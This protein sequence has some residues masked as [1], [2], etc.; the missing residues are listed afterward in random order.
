MRQGPNRE[1]VQRAL[2]RVVRQ[3]VGSAR[4]RRWLGITENAYEL[5]RNSAA[6]LLPVLLTPSPRNLTVAIT[7]QCNLR[8]VGCRYGRDY[9]TG[10]QLPTM[11]VKQLLRDAAAAGISTVRLYGGEPLLHPGLAEMVAETAAN[12]MTPYV[13]TNGRLLPRYLDRLVAAGLRTI[14]FGYYGSAA[15]YDPYVGRTGARDG[16]ERAIAQARDKYADALSLHICYVLSTRT[17]SL[18]ELETAWDLAQRYQLKF[19]LDLIHYSLPY[20]SEGPDRE[21]QFRPGDYG[22]IRPVVDRLLRMRRERPD[23]YDEPMA[24]IQS[25]PDWLLRGPDMRV[26]C[27]AYDMIWVGAD[28][29]VRLCF[30]T[31]PLGNLHQQPLRALLFTP[32]HKDAARRALKL[33]CP[34][35]HCGSD[36]R[37]VKHLPSLLR[38]SL[39]GAAAPPAA[40]PAPG[41]G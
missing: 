10:A 21:L 9:M 16:L 34:N 2:A 22:R 15:V 24:S 30:V 26:P 8:C 5:A 11:M 40:P 20:F 1:P 7:A 37:I 41:D 6:Q 25:V 35:C 38:Y 36:R 28:G 27:D 31:F 18:F 4:V 14:S 19:H 29:S 39:A 23:L 13:S 3:H 17:C 12:G 33:D 32:C